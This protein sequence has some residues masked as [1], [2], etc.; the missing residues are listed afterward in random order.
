VLALLAPARGSLKVLAV[1]GIAEKGNGMRKLGAIP[2]FLLCLQLTAQQPHWEPIGDIAATGVSHLQPDGSIVVVAG[3]SISRINADG[4]RDTAFS[5]TLNPDE[6]VAAI[7][8]Q[9]GGKILLAGVFP[10]GSQKRRVIRLNADGTRDATFRSPSEPDEFFTGFAMGPDGSFYGNTWVTGASLRRFTPDGAMDGAFQAAPVAA[11]AALIAAA[12][13]G[14]VYVAPARATLTLS[15]SRAPFLVRLL[16]DGAVDTDFIPDPGHFSVREV[17][18]IAPLPDG[19]VFVV[20]RVGPEAVNVFPTSS[21]L[22][23]LRLTRS[24]EVDF[25][26]Y[27]PI[28]LLGSG[29]RDDFRIAGVLH[30]LLRETGMSGTVRAS[31]SLFSSTPLRWDAEMLIRSDGHLLLGSSNAPLARY[32]RTAAPGPSF[33][34]APK[35][36]F[37]PSAFQGGPAGNTRSTTVV[38]GGLFPLSFQWQH[39]GIPLPAATSATL[40]L[41]NVQPSMA[42]S[43][44]VVVTNAHG[45]TTSAAV[46]LAIPSDWVAPVFVEHPSD[47]TVIA[48]QSTTLTVNVTATPAPSYQWSFNG[49]P[50]SGATNAAFTLNPT[51]LQHAG[52]YS[53]VVTSRVGGSSSSSNS[54]TAVLTVLNP[55][56]EVYRGEVRA[57]TTTGNFALAVRADRTAVL[58][59][60]FV[61][62][63]RMIVAP[64][65]RLDATGRISGSGLEY[66]AGSANTTPRTIDGSIVSG[67]TVTGTAGGTAIDFTGIR[68]QGNEGHSGYYSLAA[69]AAASATV[70][71]V[72]SADGQALVA[73][74]SG[75]IIDGGTGSVDSS[76]HLRA[77]LISGAEFSGTIE[78]NGAITAAIHRGVFAGRIFGG[79]RD[80]ALRTNR[81]GNLATRGFV[82]PDGRNLVAGFVVAGTGSRPLLLRGIGPTL[83]SFG[84]S[85][86]L[87]DPS[88]T[89]YQN[90]NALMFSD[91]WPLETG[92]AQ[93][94]ATS[95]RLGAFAL[96]NSRDAAASRTTSAG[97]YTVEINGNHNA[98][99]VA[100]VEVY[101]DD[102]TNN[103]QSGARLINL[104][105]R[106]WVGTGEALLVAGFVIKGNAPQRLLVRAVGPGLGGFGVNGTLADPVL[107][108]FDSAGTPLLGNDDW[109]ASAAEAMA[110]MS[111]QTVAGAFPLAEGSRDAALLLSLQPGAYTAQITAKNG[112]TGVALAEIYVVP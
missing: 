71:V 41:P 83:A 33:D 88:L 48:G 20:A 79:L 47:R 63:Q 112:N 93:L 57:G 66:S 95:A 69:I 25:A 45:S 59:M 55:A 56:T 1:S 94:I 36:I 60:S 104:S 24:G 103:T 8:T 2:L 90:T 58:V 15:A 92:A 51:E 97:N 100:L 40:T 96:P 53:V 73:L 17:L 67:G 35:I 72:V 109:S 68:T 111:A 89:L 21:Y 3:G 110:I 9:P 61:A 19:R 86:A 28:H 12:A 46:Q 105:T 7:A 23:L 65:L 87:S 39:N 11:G 31:V 102:L 82:G 32:R 85:E 18:S 64:A 101:E 50:I 77:D 98:A 74:Q 107:T 38:A 54:R 49:A 106:G 14:S 27:V 13:D 52:N 26:H 76:G 5:V 70:H 29:E 4:S 62:A 81:L 75:A 34:A 42:G 30:D 80:G 91:D 99:G 37:Q 44:A 10:Q 16:R 108:V 22:R 84:I 6:S 43:Y 78:A